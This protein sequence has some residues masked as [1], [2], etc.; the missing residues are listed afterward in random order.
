MTLKTNFKL[1]RLR[2]RAEFLFVDGRAGKDCQH[3]PQYCAKPALIVQT[4]QNPEREIGVRCGFTATKKTGNAVYRNRA[5]RRMRALA[6]EFLP[7]L[8]KQGFDYVFIARH[9]TKDAPF[10]A[11][12]KDCEKALLR[13][14]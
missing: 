4:R 13:L 3:K 11:L 7:T 2:T 6:R 10:E 5:K 8:G 9:T 12:R 14:Q 1:G